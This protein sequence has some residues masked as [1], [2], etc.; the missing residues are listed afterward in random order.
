M[1][2]RAGPRRGTA[3]GVRPSPV[4][5]RAAGPD[6]SPPAG[7][8]ST[9]GPSGAIF[10]GRPRVSRCLAARP[11]TCPA[12]FLEAPRLARPRPA[13]PLLPRW[14]RSCGRAGVAG[15]GGGGAAPLPAQ[16][17]EEVRAPKG[18]GRRRGGRAAELGA[19]AVRP[20]P[21]SPVGAGLDAPSRAP[22]AAGSTGPGAGPGAEQARAAPCW[23]PRARRH[24]CAR[25][26][27]LPRHAPR[28][29]GRS[30]AGRVETRR[31]SNRRRGGGREK[32]EE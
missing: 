13:R 10:P 9:A 23:P 32:I 31:R 30:R 20:P 27:H 4:P 21:L 14:R 7:S 2:L 15:G 12:G 28:A 18:E 5:R 24:R 6:S 26:L 11:W 17:W 25:V 3:P 1:T 22:A 19:G 8:Q 29:L 16:V